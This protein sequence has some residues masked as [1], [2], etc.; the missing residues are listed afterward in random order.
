MSDRDKARD[1]ARRRLRLH[2]LVYEG[3][4]TEADQLADRLLEES[5]NDVN[6]TYLKGANYFQAKRFPEALDVF[7][8]ILTL[9]ARN[10]DAW[11]AKGICLAEQKLY[12]SSL[13]AYHAA[14][15]HAPDDPFT[16]N[17]MGKAL[18]NLGEH[19]EAVDAFARAVKAN[20]RFAEAWHYLAVSFDSAGRTADALACF[21][22]AVRVDPARADAWVDRGTHFAREAEKDMRQDDS[23]AGISLLYEALRSYECALTNDPGH[24]AASENRASILKLLGPKLASH[25]PNPPLGAPLV[26][27]KESR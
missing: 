18:A 20:P 25:R 10:V 9:D 24:P 19:T 23:H 27:I 6:I 11:R 16:L 22:Q 1:V 13:P 3:M 7:D 21:D 5:P 14:L 8:A 15:D 17:E 2:R 4:F 26:E 12:A